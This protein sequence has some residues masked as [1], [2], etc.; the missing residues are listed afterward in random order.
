MTTALDKPVTRLSGLVMPTYAGSH[1]GRAVLV[2][3]TASKVIFRAQGTKTRYSI[4]LEKALGLA[5]TAGPDIL[6]RD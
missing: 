4:P 1:R 6:A 3:I 5:I 2:T